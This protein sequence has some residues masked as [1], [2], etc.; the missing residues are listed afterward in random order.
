VSH[1]PLNTEEEE[2][3]GGDDGDGDGALVEAAEEVEAAE[4][5]QPA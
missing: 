5:G 2:E 3:A 1:L 4:V